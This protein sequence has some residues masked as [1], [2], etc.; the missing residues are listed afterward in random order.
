MRT[1]ALLVA[2]VLALQASPARAEAVVTK[3]RG[4]LSGVGLGL[5]IAG[6]AGAGAGVAGVFASNAAT[7]R[8]TAYGPGAIPAEE[9]ASVTALQT[10]ASGSATLAVIGFV[11]GGLALVGGITCLVVDGLGARTSV[12]FVPT[13]QGGALVFSARF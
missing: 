1:T 13:S 8:L 4:F 9:Q 5:L 10:R 6:L 3:Q 7:L 12:V 2:A 11:A